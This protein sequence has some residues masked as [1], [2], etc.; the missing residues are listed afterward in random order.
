MTLSEKI[1]YLKQLLN[2]PEENYVDAF[3]ADITM[4][5]C[6]VISRRDTIKNKNDTIFK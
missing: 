2:Q 1:E 4:F 6:I 5:L 3:K